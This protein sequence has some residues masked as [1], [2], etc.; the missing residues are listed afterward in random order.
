MTILL[1]IVLVLLLFG[2]GWGYRSG[3]VAYHDPLGIVLILLFVIVIFGLVG[4][5]YFYR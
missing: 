3:A 4:Y 1:V 5:P 2:G